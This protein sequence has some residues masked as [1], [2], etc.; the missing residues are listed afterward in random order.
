VLDR[1][2]KHLFRKALGVD[3]RGIEKIDSAFEAY[4]NKT[5]RFS[6]GGLAP[7]P[8]ELASATESAG[9]KAEDRDLQP[10]VS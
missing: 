5:R 6:Y 9:A 10:A 7:C 3:I 1:L 2:A 8:E 4:V